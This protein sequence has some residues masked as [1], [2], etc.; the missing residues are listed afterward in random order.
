MPNALQRRFKNLTHWAARE[1]VI[2]IATR[3]GWLYVC[4][5]FFHPKDGSIF[6]QFPYFRDRNGVATVV[7][8]ERDG[9]TSGTIHFLEEGKVTSHLIK[10]SHHPDGRVHFSQDRKVKTEIKRQANLPLNGPTGRLFDLNV[11]RPAAGFLPLDQS[12]MKRGRPHLVFDYKDDVPSAIRIRGSW[13]K[14]TDVANWSRPPE[15][16]LGPSAKVESV[17]DGTRSTAFFLGQ[18]EGY[19]LQD[20]VLVVMCNRI[21]LPTGVEEPTLLFFGGSDANEVLRPGDAA[22]PSEFLAAMYPVH[23]RDELERL[24]GTIDYKSETE[25]H[26][27]PAAET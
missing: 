1:C 23:D 2:G 21:V 19:P 20:H 5:L 13:R 10:Y 16:P 25:D 15:A 12:R 6:V 17:V 14:K 18:P 3:A 11:F 7:R 9:R 8:L 4:H 24:V 27:T 22:P 26:A